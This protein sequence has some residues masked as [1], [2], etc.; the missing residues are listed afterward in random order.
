L[1]PS[2]L[3]ACRTFVN[4]QLNSISKPRNYCFPSLSPDVGTIWSA[5]SLSQSF[6]RQN[7]FALPLR[8]SEIILLLNPS[9]LNAFPPRGLLTSLIFP[10]GSVFQPSD[11]TP[12]PARKSMSQG[13]LSRPLLIRPYF[14]S[15]LHVALRPRPLVNPSSGKNL[16]PGSHLLRHSLFKFFFRF[17]PSLGFIFY[18]VGSFYLQQAKQITFPGQDV[19]FHGSTAPWLFPKGHNI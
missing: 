5:L 3:V 2:W 18:I 6:S 4:L 16:P 11:L 14:H 17:L 19:G 9:L 7:F 15:E 10:F 1:V 13:A 8:A 12:H